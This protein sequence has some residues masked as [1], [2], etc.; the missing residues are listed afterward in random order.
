MPRK[1]DDKDDDE[2]DE[3]DEIKSPFDFMKFLGDPNKLF[4][5]KQFRHLFKN[6]FDRIKDNLPPEFQNM[7]AEDINEEFLKDKSKFFKGPFMYG[8]NVGIGPDGKP[9]INSFGNLKTS[10]ETPGKAEINPQREPLVEVAEQGENIIVIA[11]MPGVTK[12]DIELKATARSLTI[13]TKTDD[14]GRNYYKEI[15]LPAEIN[16]DY[17]KARYQNGILEVKLLKSDQKHTNI[18]VE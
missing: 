1:R 8:F 6:I 3:E 17:A 9:N 11:E 7:S 2:E 4:Q 14:I 18:K 13:S 10:P 12:D 5:S 15:D 16:T